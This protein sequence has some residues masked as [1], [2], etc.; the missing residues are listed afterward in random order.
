MF[1]PEL[2]TRVSA[3]I[4]TSEIDNALSIIKSSEILSQLGIDDL[5]EESKNTLQD[6]K[7]PLANAV[8][9]RLSSNQ[10]III[11]TKHYIT[12]LMSNSVDIFSDGD[13]YIVGNT[14]SSVTGFP[15]PLAIEKGTGSHWVAPVTY[16]VLHWVE[17]GEDKY[18]KGHMVSGIK[19]DPFVQPSIDLT[20]ADIDSIF[21]DL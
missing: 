12:G 11:S 13:D 20:L 3:E 4:D 6:L 17:D 8:A 15:Y 1:E 14:A 18:S 21:N 19:A 10:E 7:D 9:E 2:V 16:N 5:L